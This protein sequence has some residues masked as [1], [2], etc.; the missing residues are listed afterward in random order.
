MDSAL[1]DD[2][3]K[4]LNITFNGHWQEITEQVRGIIIKDYLLPLGYNISKA[5]MMI[6]I[7]NGYP[8]AALDMFYLHP[9]ICK[10]NSNVISALTDE[11]HFGKSWQRWSR[12][13]LWIPGV[14]NLSTHMRVIQ[15]SLKQEL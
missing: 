6:I 10:Q 1:T 4:Y 11:V 14:H 15:N 8:M 13:Y 12:H 7:P 9:K 2:D 5:E 3:I